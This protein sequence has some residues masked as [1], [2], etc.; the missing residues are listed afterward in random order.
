MK[1][2]E[3]PVETIDLIIQRK[4]GQSYHLICCTFA[5]PSPAAESSRCK[6]RVMDI[7]RK[8]LDE[9]VVG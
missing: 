1:D 9:A 3:R 7:K 6:A 5:P 8:G 4:R 2:F